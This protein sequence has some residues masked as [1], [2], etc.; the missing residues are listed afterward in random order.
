ME[1]ALADTGVWYGIFD[2]RD[3]HYPEAQIKAEFFD[4]FKIVIP[5]PTIYE[6]LRTNFVRKKLALQLF[7][8]FLKTHR[9]EYLDD[10]FYRNNAL[11]FSLESSL[12]KHRPLSMVDC[13]LRLIIDDPNIK[14][15]YLLTFN[16]RDFIDVCQKNRVEIL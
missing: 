14:I 10:T 7:E 2:S 1:Y 6:T 12:R 11:D 16:P 8:S 15:H 13:L 5:W 4:A 3:Q 9:I